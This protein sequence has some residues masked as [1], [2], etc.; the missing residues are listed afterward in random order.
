M[1]LRGAMTKNRSKFGDRR[2]D[3][4]IPRI[5]FK[6][7]TGATIRECRRR[8]PDRRIG[9]IHAEWIDEVVTV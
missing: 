9:N 7:S 8:T 2:Q 1:T 4:G 3:M 5:P 6:D